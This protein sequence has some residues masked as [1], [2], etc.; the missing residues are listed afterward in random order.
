MDM[1]RDRGRGERLLVLI[2]NDPVLSERLT[3]VLANYHFRVQ[4]IP[5]G[6]DLLMGPQLHPVLIVLCIDPKRLGWAICNKIKKTVQYRDVPMIVTSQEATEKDFDDHKKL[7]TRAEEYLHKPYSVELLLSKIDPLVGLDIAAVDQ[8]IETIDD[9]AIEEISVD[10]AVIEEELPSGPLALQGRGPG[11]AGSAAVDD[12][13]DLETD[14][15][16]DAIGANQASRKSPLQAV[17]SVALESKLGSGPHPQRS[18]DSGR[19]GRFGLPGVSVGLLEEP[20]K[21]LPRPPDKPRE[22]ER[23]PVRESERPRP[24]EPA[25]AGGPAEDLPTMHLP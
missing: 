12:D 6:N 4:V 15:A 2:D 3:A 5:D 23:E 16:F 19:S 22:P 25:W 17:A 20:D 24:P 21:A 1:D 14:A 8:P 11:A 7:R 18:S 10:D 9:A 13:I